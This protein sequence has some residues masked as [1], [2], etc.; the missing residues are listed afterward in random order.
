[1]ENKIN[2]F[3][4][5]TSIDTMIHTVLKEALSVKGLIRGLHQCTKAIESQKALLC[6]LAT[7]CDDANY[8]KLVEALC[9]EHNIPMLKVLVIVNMN[10]N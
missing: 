10:S 6:M 7:N 3:E 9:K 2:N 1:M 5:A 4:E 8:T